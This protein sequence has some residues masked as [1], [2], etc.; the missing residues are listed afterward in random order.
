MLSLFK[1]LGVGNLRVIFFFLFLFST[2]VAFSDGDAD[3]HI[4]VDGIIT[5]EDQKLKGAIVT[6]VN[7]ENYPEV[8]RSIVTP[9]NGKFIF[10]LKPDKEYLI[11]ASKTGHVTKKILFST[12]NVPDGRVSKEFT[13]F[14]IEISLFEDIEGLN[15]SILK[16]PIGKITYNDKINDFDVDKDYAKS[17]HAQ[18]LTL[19]KELQAIRKKAISDERIAMKRLV[20]AKEASERELARNRKKGIKRLENTV[21]ETAARENSAKEA[22]VIEMIRATSYKIPVVTEKVNLTKDAKNMA[23]PSLP[24]ETEKTINLKTEHKFNNKVAPISVVSSTRNELIKSEFRSLL[25]MEYPE[26]VTEES[27]I[28]GNIKIIKRIV[29]QDGHAVEYNK[30]THPWGG[31]FYFKNGKSITKHIFD[32]ETNTDLLKSRIKE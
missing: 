8:T 23:L 14:P 28:E 29:I 15:I 21:R 10:I 30:V 18:V 31:V 7:L 24:R 16:N 22:V 19:Q 20:K 1:L 13:Y 4:A 25:A 12:K 26:G 6:L 32:L 27:I 9:G 17:I 2:S 11:I 3:W 5:K